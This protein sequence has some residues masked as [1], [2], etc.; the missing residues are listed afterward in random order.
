MDQQ[1]PSQPPRKPGK[2]RQMRV[3]QIRPRGSPKEPPPELPKREVGTEAKQPSAFP[4]VPVPFTSMDLAPGILQA[5]QEMGYELAT[6]VQATA[7]PKARTGRDLMVQS[8]TGTGKTAAF[9]IPI[10]E[11]VDASRKDVQAL[12]L[13]PTRELCLQVT[14][15]IG[16]LGAASGVKSL[17]IYGGDSMT[18]QVN[19]LERGSQVV[20]GTPG[21]L[22]DHLRQRTLR[23]DAVRTLVLDEAD[24]M[25][26]M[27]FEKEMKAILEQ[28]PKDRQT[29]MFS[30]TIPSGIEGIM[31]RYQ[32][33]PER[34]MLSQDVL[35]VADVL[36]LFYIVS[37]MAKTAALYKLIEWENPTSSMIF[38]NTKAEP[39]LVHGYLS[40]HALPPPM[41]SSALP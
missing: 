13:C 33:D 25:L 17:A 2:L 35:Y 3:T 4:D 22:L 41:I 12:I 11:K 20:V 39:R 21:R 30:A 1:S 24:Q 10:I 31:R 37:R 18:R 38:C 34:V 5:L 15:E 27:G 32:K 6:E 9:G 16:R 23:L 8:R 40:I 7:I 14:G 29:L 19:G 36:H 28:V 26:D